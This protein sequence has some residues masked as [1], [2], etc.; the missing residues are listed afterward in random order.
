MARQRPLRRNTGS[1]AR[2]CDPRVRG[3]WVRWCL[4]S[5]DRHTRRSAPAADQLPLRF[6]ARPVACRRR[7]ALRR[8]ADRVDVTHAGRSWTASRTGGWHSRVRPPRRPPP[9]TQP[10]HGAR[11][12]RAVRTPRLVGDH[13]RTGAIRS[14]GQSVGTA[15]PATRGHRRGQRHRVL[16]DARR[17]AR[18][19]TPTR[20][21]HD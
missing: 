7:F 21:R 9:R 6:Q 16:P 10:H 13:V 17:R 20:R 11:V 18:C 8:A 14:R 12:R 15:A 4:D 5:G 3:P 2:R 1:P 19:C